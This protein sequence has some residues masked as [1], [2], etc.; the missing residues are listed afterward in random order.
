MAAMRGFLLLVCCGL[1]GCGLS[2]ATR[3]QRPQ[4]SVS[5]AARDSDRAVKPSRFATVITPAADYQPLV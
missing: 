5:T 2:G 3:L 4:A 1:A